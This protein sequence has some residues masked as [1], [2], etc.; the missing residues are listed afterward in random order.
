MHT[1]LLNKTRIIQNQIWTIMLGYLSFRGSRGRVFCFC[2]EW[3]FPILSRNMQIEWSRPQENAKY[4]LIP[5][6][7]SLLI[8]SAIL[9]SSWI[10]VWR[11]SRPIRES[12]CVRIILPDELTSRI[13]KNKIKLVI[14]W[15]NMTILG[16]SELLVLDMS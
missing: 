11:H 1:F 9:M 7:S 14:L 16:A 6:L 8:A 12:T 13:I 3:C 15:Q 10:L 5:N 2:K 4:L